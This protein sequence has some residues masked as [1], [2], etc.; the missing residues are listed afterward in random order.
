[1]IIS[2]VVSILTT[3]YLGPSNYGLISYGSAYVSFFTALC[4]LGLNSIIVKELLDHP[5]EQGENI[6]SCLMLR[7]AS[8]VISSIMMISLS[9]CLDSGETTTIKVVALCSLS[10]I[11]HIFEIFNFWFQSQYKSKLTAIAT[12]V[13]Y[14]FT[15]IYKIILLLLGKNVFWFAFATSFDYIILAIFLFIFYKKNKGPKLSF[16]LK[17]SKYLL[18]KSYHYILS[19]L[20][21][22][23]YSQTDKLM[24]KQMINE[25]EVGYYSIA[26]AICMMWTFVL[27]AIIDSIYPTILKLKN[28]NEEQYKTKNRQLYCIVFYISLVVSICFTIFG[29]LIVFILYGKEFISAVPILRIVTWYIAFSYLGVARNAWIVSEGKQNKLKYL[30]AFAA[31]INVI[32]NFILIPILGAAGAAIASLLAE[33]MISLILPLF[34]KDLRENAVLMLEAI[35]FRKVK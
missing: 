2:L 29:K 1:M 18:K 11:F 6:G 33:M 34:S 8:S 5:E 10:P 14:I 21:V 13:A 26:I 12:L 7:F 20:M 28:V 22:V 19:G 31:V 9:F 30:Y 24:I 16:S 27:Q 35:C 17:K 4:T 15:S 32:F 23:I 25:E 3:R